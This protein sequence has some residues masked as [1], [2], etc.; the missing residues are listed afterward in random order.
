MR[1][2]WSSRKIRVLAVDTVVSLILFFSARLLAPEYQGDVV[3]LI[4]IIQP[5]VLAVVLG[6]AWED[7]SAKRAGV[8]P[9]QPPADKPGKKK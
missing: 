4:G 6:I 3:L 5:A 7:A 9:G 1:Q 2:L 8:F